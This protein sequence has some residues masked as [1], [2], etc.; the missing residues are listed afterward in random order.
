MHPST[1]IPHTDNEHFSVVEIVMHPKYKFNYAF[2]YALLRLDYPVAD[3]LYG[4]GQNSQFRNEFMI[5]LIL[6]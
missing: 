4:I 5:L 1:H 6:E 3:N 2:D